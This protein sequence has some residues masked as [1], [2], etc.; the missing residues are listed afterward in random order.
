MIEGADGKERD[1]AQQDEGEEESGRKMV[2][3]GYPWRL[4]AGC[5]E[6]EI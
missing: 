6:A 1:H 5:A 2:A 3:M 4:I